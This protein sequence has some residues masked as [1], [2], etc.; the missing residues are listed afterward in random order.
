MKETRIDEKWKKFV[1]VK[2]GRNLCSNPC[3]LKNK[4][5]LDTQSLANK[6]LVP[7]KTSGI[8]FNM[9]F[10]FEHQGIEYPDIQFEVSH[11]NQYRLLVHVE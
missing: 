9:I 10:I 4:I 1:W 11:L 2:P 8:V 6:K 7:F 5:R 3:P